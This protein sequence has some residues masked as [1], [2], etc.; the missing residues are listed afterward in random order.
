MSS[1]LNMG[2]SRTCTHMHLPSSLSL[3]HMRER[4]TDRE[5]ERDNERERERELKTI[6]Q[7]VDRYELFFFF[8]NTWYV[9]FWY[10]VS[11]NWTGTEGK[12]CRWKQGGWATYTCML[13]SQLM[14]C[15]SRISLVGGWYS[16]VGQDVLLQV[17][18]ELQKS[19]SGSVFLFYT[20]SPPNPYMLSVDHDVHFWVTALV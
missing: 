8:E 5:R 11:C 7:E 3:T 9:V 16:L 13:N 4:E 12:R 18:F 19:M 6:K 17:G 1:I 20:C 10:Q 14:N 15:L 2:C